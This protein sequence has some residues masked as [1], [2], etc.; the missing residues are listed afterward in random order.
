MVY[1]DFSILLFGMAQLVGQLQWA[2]WIS[3]LKILLGLAKV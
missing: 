3:A 2:I 1:E